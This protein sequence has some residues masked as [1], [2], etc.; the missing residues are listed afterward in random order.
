MEWGEF[1]AWRRRTCGAWLWEW[2]SSC[3]SW[4]STSMN[5]NN[6]Y[7][8]L[9]LCHF[10]FLPSCHTYYW[11]PAIILAWNHIHIQL[12]SLRG[13]GGLEGKGS[14]LC[15]GLIDDSSLL[16]FFLRL[17]LWVC[18]CYI[19][20]IRETYYDDVVMM[21]LFLFHYFSTTYFEF[22]NCTSHFSYRSF[23]IFF[24][25]IYIYDGVTKPWVH[26]RHKIM[27]PHLVKVHKTKA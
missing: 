1:R 15:W 22:F 17:L 10:A 23:S 3:S 6:N 25:Y 9:K 12:N 11:L 21:M 27:G 18:C 8:S 4:S 7:S 13:G 20:G 19:T 14:F 26:R 2:V 24:I 16:V 5:N